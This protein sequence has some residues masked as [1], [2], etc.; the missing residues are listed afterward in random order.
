[1][2]VEEISTLIKQVADAEILS[3]FRNLKE[4]EVYF[5]EPGEFVTAADV[6]AEKALCAGLKK[7]YPQAIV[8]GEEDIAE[9][10][11]SMHELL[12]AELGFLIDPVDGT[13]NF[14]KGNERFAVMIVALRKGAAVASF[15]YLPAKDMMCYAIKDE[16]VFLNEEK[17]ILKTP[18][19]SL[20]KMVG[21]A[22]INRMPSDVRA[23]AKE[24]LSY[25]KEN[26]P[27]Y[28]AGYDYVSLLNGSKDFSAYYRTLLWD[29]LPGVLLFTEAGGY[30]RCLDGK[31]YT[32]T[33]D[34]IGLLCAANEKIWHK[35]K[36]TLFP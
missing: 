31:E 20:E 28:C 24:G 23:V 15:I 5:K 6:A 22:H 30:A 21:A 27:S 33:G 11:K 12:N 8:T 4:T 14:I 1:M 19:L 9:N 13:N 18:V 3:R 26:K 34:S 16:G 29:H 17:I 25:I 32:A 36:Q 7:L 35:L 2:K 10:P